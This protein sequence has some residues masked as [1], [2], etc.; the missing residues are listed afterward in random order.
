MTE[1]R[2]HWQTVPSARVESEA[3]SDADPRAVV[4]PRGAASLRLFGRRRM[5]TTAALLAVLTVV[6]IVRSQGTPASPATVVSLAALV[7]ASSAL[8]TFVPTHG[9]LWHLH[10]G[11]GPCAAAGGLLG[12][13]AVWMAAGH[14]TDVGSATLA[15]GAAGIA[16][17]QRLTEPA[18]CPTPSRPPVPD[19]RPDR[20][21]STPT[22]GEPHVP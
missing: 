14:P 3:G 17:V 6:L 9:R 13:G 11:C 1:T 10:L 2:R 18:A 21:T 19:T 16:L 5:V 12:L 15:F 8:S 22:E 20:P 4:E 7:L